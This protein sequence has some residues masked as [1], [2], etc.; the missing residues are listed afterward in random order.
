MIECEY[1]KYLIVS[2]CS[3][4]WVSCKA[5]LVSENYFS[6]YDYR[7]SVFLP[8]EPVKIAIVVQRTTI[9][10]YLEEICMEAKEMLGMFVTQLT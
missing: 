10:L 5:S 3:R 8:H 9:T 6:L 2:F 1:S 7:P 4:S